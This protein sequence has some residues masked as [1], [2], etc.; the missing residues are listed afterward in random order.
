MFTRTRARAVAAGEGVGVETSSRPTAGARGC[1]AG[2]R[3]HGRGQA[4]SGGGCVLVGARDRIPA[5]GDHGLADPEAEVAELCGFGRGEVGVPLGEV[6]DRVIHPL[7]LLFFGGFEHAAAV[8]MAEELV[9]SPF[10]E[11]GFLCATTQPGPPGAEL[12]GWSVSCRRGLR[13]DDTRKCYLTLLQARCEGRR[14]SLRGGGKFIAS[15]WPRWR[16]RWGQRCGGRRSRRTS[17][18]GRTPR[19]RCAMVKAGWS[20]WGTTCRCTSARCRRAWSLRWSW[21]RAP[22]MWW[23]RTTRSR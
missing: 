8:D 12:E 6:L 2:A 19:A 16:K 10:E 15:S 9:A 5:V 7:A 1:R 3:V 13:V 14:R 11:R 17:G 22:A 4:G 23:C 20:R 21:S 18:S